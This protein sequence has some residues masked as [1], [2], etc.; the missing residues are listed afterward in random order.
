M[1]MKYLCL[2]YLKHK[3]VLHV[4]W[5]SLDSLF[6]QTFRGQNYLNISAKNYLK[7]YFSFQKKKILGEFS[8]VSHTVY[9]L[10]GTWDFLK[11]DL[12]TWF[13]S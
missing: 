8:H 1:F 3:V 13:R 10:A 6:M 2:T 12:E 5:H 9:V 7:K 11:T 4:C